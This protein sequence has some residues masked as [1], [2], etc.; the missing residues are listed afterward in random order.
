MNI[1]RNELDSALATLQSLKQQHATAEANK[2]KIFSRRTPL[3]LALKE[4]AERLESAQMRNLRG[5]VSDD[6]VATLRSEY[7]A[8]RDALVQQNEDEET[9]SRAMNM[10]NEF[11]EASEAL[12]IAR[13]NYFGA[14]SERIEKSL[15]TDA[16]LRGRLINDL[17]ACMRAVGREPDEPSGPDGGFAGRQWTS[18]L[19]ACFPLPASDELLRGVSKFTAEYGVDA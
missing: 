3:T 17:V 16:K 18:V 4:A 15:H 7:Q 12:G 10:M 6:E 5:L 14:I 13:S 11:S 9:A 8:A 1:N 19:L 2:D